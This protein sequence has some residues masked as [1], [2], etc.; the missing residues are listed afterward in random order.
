[1][2][3]SGSMLPPERTTAT[4]GSNERGSSSSAATPAAPAGSTTSFARSRQSSRARDNDSSDTVTISSTSSRTRAN[5]T[6]AGTADRDAVGHR[7]HAVQRNRVARCQRRREGG[8]ALGL[9]ADDPHV[10]PDRLHGQRDAGEQPAAAGADHHRAHVR[11]PARGSRARRSPARPR[12][13][14]GRTGAPA[15]RR[16]PRR[17]PWP[18]AAPRPPRSRAN[19]T[20]APYALVA[21]TLGI[22]APSGMNTVELRP[23]SEAASATPWAWLPALAATTPCARLVLGQPRDPGVRPTDLE[24]AGPL[25]VLALEPDRP[26]DPFGQ[27]PGAL[28]RGV[29]DDPLEQLA[30]GLDVLDRDRQRAHGGQCASPVR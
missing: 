4:G 23:S 2:S 7:R 10:R 5:G 30:G 28:H 15:P 27:R 12:C 25:Q 16:S 13:P 22:G 20:C 17:R 1:M 8:C 19:R 14:G 24:R 29:P 9:Y 21:C 26:A 6:V 18:P 3:S 11:A